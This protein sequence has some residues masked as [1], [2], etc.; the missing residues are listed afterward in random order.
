[1]FILGVILGSA[2]VVGVQVFYFLRY[3]RPFM[4][5]GTF[6]N[7]RIVYEYQDKG[8]PLN[9]KKVWRIKQVKGL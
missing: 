7:W 9:T 6:M 8:D 4:E 5:W 3:G 2:A 1:M